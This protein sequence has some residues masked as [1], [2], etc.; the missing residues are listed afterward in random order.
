MSLNFTKEACVNVALHMKDIR[1]KEK[2]TY[3]GRTA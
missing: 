1:W 3:Y 2:G